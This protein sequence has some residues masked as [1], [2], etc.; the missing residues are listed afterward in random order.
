MASQVGGGG[1]RKTF[2][3]TVRFEGATVILGGTM[4]ACLIVLYESTE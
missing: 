4:Y 1:L 3:S 2:S